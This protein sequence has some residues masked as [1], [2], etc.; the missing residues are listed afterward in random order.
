MPRQAPRRASPYTART[1]ALTTK[2][3]KDRAVSL[4]LRL[5]LG[6]RL[7]VPEGIDTDALGT[8]TGEIPRVGI[9]RET[10]ARKARL[11][12]AA[13]GIP[14]GLA[15]EGSFGPDPAVPFIAIDHE[16][17]VFIDDELGIAVCE[18]ILTTET[19][20]ACAD[21]A[22]VA[23]LEAFLRRA[24]FPSH[25][26]I[27]RPRTG[28]GPADIHKGIQ[29]L[30][31]LETAFAMA[32]RRSEDGLARIETDMRAHVN[33][34]RARVIRHLAF[35]LARRVRTHCPACDT[36]G[37][38]RVDVVPGLPC[39]WCGSPTD[40]VWHEIHAC[41][42][43]DHREHRPRSDDLTVADPGQCSYCNP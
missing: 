29:S 23:E 36:P 27:V 3:G 15:S 30:A 6:A 33:P 26:V 40:L 13:L 42:R 43:C 14:L 18:Q 34:S 39:R 8:F 2:H 37:W 20:Y 35:T 41:P 10:A 22:S 17:L 19:N 31:G 21:V 5:G 12:M 24:H 7:V 28:G 38:G 11:G 4:P 16:L 1:I 32:A 25:A 9:P